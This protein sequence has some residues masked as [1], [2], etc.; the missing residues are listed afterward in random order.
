[1]ADQIV[2]KE[3]YFSPEEVFVMLRYPDKI[4]KPSPMPNM[5]GAFGFETSAE[6]DQMSMEKPVTQLVD[7]LEDNESILKVTESVLK[8][9]KEMEEFFGLGL[10]MTNCNY[11]VMLP[12]AFNPMHSDSS[13]LD[14]T[15]Y[16][17]NEETE[18]SALIYLNDSGI[19]YE[20]G[21][22]EFPL[23]KTVVS[24]KSGTVIFFKGD[25]YHPH[26]VKV[27]TKGERKAL[28]LFFGL[29]GNVSGRPLFSDEY[30]GVPVPAKE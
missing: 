1:M 17:E 25:H 6:A 27:V 15:P 30:S 3:G 8:V 29:K 21:D 16:H 4:K 11:A 14:G 13:Q 7:D 24:P 28:V 26:E 18:Y 10:S 12:G 9:K 22:I 2:V 5:E 19:D 23:Q 20:G